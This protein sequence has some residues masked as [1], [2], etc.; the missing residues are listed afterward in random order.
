MLSNRNV[1]NQEVSYEHIVLQES[2]KLLPEANSSHEGAPDTI[3]YA[4][5]TLKFVG[6]YNRGVKLSL[7]C[8]DNRCPRKE[9]S[10]KYVFML[11]L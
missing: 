8:R 10:D 1:K 2:S 7:S 9:V 6:R 5:G 11:N 3:Q 4:S